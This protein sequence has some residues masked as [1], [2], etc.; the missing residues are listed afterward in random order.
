M[1]QGFSGKTVVITG[2]SA[3]VGAEAARLFF[4]GGARLVLAARGEDALRSFAAQ[5]GIRALAVPMDVADD[6]AC[7]QLLETAEQ[8]FGAVHVLVNNAGCNFRGAVAEF[9]AHELARIVD[10][11]LRAP[12]LLSRLAL[13]FIER[14]G[15]GAIVNVASIAGKIPVPYEATYSATKFGLRAFTHAFAEELD[16]SPISVSCVSPGPVDTG[17]IMSS[18]DKVPDYFF[19]Q[20]ISTAREVA[21]LV[22]ACAADGE[23]ERTIPVTTGWLATAGYL[24][25]GL[26]R[27]LRPALARKGRRIKEQYRRANEAGQAGRS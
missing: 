9:E 20:P 22:V 2:A 16:D 11:N 4:D 25:P 1:S 27:L 7:V 17:F 21:E 15:G 23:T 6:D 19:S 13:P 10:V 24:V 5:F 12:V 14:A 8:R 3:G 18:L 26:A